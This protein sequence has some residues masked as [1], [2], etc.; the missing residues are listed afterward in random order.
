MN[1]HDNPRLTSHVELERSFL[2]HLSPDSRAMP[3]AAASGQSPE[4]CPAAGGAAG[5]QQGA[6]ADQQPPK[7]DKVCAG[8]GEAAEGGAARAAAGHPA[9]LGI[10]LL[11]IYFF[12]SWHMPKA[13]QWHKFV[14]C[15]AAAPFLLHLIA[16]AL[17]SAPAHI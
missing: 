11:L 15:S 14:C 7:G 2:G 13:A 5:H 12:I 16:R 17:T 4:G 10:Q 6:R 9:A 8:G 3:A 1:S